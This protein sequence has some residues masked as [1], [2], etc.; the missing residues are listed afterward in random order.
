MKVVIH[1]LTKEE[2]E[3]IADRYAGWHVI[4]ANK[5]GNPCIGCFGCWVKDPGECVIK[6]GVD[7]VGTLMHHAEEVT[8]ISRYT[9]GGFSSHVK[10]VFDRSIG[11]VLPFFEVVDGE[12]H[13]KKR[14]EKCVPMTFVFRGK[15]LTE[16]EKAQ[17]KKYVEAVCRNLRSSVKGVSFE[18]TEDL[19]IDIENAGGSSAWKKNSKKSQVSEELPEHTTIL[20]NCSL[21]ADNANSKKFLDRLSTGIAGNKKHINLSTYLKKKEELI[22][23]LMQAD[24]V[25]LGIPLYVDGIPSAPLQ[26][27]EKMEQILSQVAQGDAKADAKTDAWAD[28]TNVKNKRIYVVANMGLYESRQLSNLLYMVRSWCDKCGMIYSGGVAIGAG[29]MLGNMMKAQR[30][31][32]GPAGNVAVAFDRLVN[33]MNAD[34]GMEDA[35]VEPAGFPRKIYMF[36]ANLGWPGDGKKNGLKKKDLYRQK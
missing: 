29:E 35:F 13:H 22:P 33:A 2:W 23:M 8:V 30:I 9:Y 25:V 21:R 32:K 31:D 36:L 34:D 3:K 26:L 18:E 15:N 5:K 17:G 6:D 1:D 10:R 28:S 11:G 14:Y 19:G 24:K 7:N 16:E 4:A 12:M 27:M 20:L